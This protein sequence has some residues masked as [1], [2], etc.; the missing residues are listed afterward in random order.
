MSGLT[1]CPKCGQTIEPNNELVKLST[2]TKVFIGVEFLA[3]LA[4]G[5]IYYSMHHN[6]PEYVRTMI[7]PDSTLADQFDVKF[8]TIKVDTAQTNKEDK[9]ESEKAAK[10]FNSIRGNQSEEPKQDEEVDI[11]DMPAGTD[12]ETAQPGYPAN[13]QPSSTHEAPAPPSVEVI[14]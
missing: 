5:F 11:E 4:C 2:F 12:N 6:D 10:V 7:E 3:L 8:D 13:D 14:E 9:S 1:V